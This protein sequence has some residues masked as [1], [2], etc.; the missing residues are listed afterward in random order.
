MSDINKKEF[1]LGD[2]VKIISLQSKCN[3][4]CCDVGVGAAGVIIDVD[5]DSELKYSVE[6][7]DNYWWWEEENLELV[8]EEETMSEQTQN[9]YDVTPKTPYQEKGFTE[10]S[11]FKFVGEDGQFYNGELIKLHHLYLVRTYPLQYLYKNH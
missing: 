10:N 3:R 5:E 2:K 8:E 11:L 1:H 6:F 9:T 4:G 7:E